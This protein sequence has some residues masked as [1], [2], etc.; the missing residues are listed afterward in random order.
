MRAQYSNQLLASFVLWIDNKVTT[1]GEAHTTVSTR[2][3][4][5]SML[6]N[7]YYTYSAPYDQ[8]IADSSI[9]GATIMTGVYVNN[10]FIGTGQ[11]GLYSI[12]YQN[13]RTYF[14]SELPAGTIISGTYS[15]KDYNVVMT[16]SPD[17]RILFETRYSPKPKTTQTLSG[18]NSDETPYPVIFVRSNSMENI[19]FEFGGTELSKDY[20][21]VIVMS[22][23]QFSN[24]AVNSIIRDT[25]NGYVPI[26]EENEFPFNYM[27]N[28]KS[29]YNYTGIAANKTAQGSAAFV[30]NIY[31][32]RFDS[33]QYAQEI[34]ELS[35]EVYTSIIDVHLSHPR[36]ITR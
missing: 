2:F 13:G 31:I 1:L 16:S 24:D 12:D 35:P 20:I 22:D 9:S 15:I 32:A 5:N 28:L 7:G 18:L 21:R 17:E 25:K 36:Q 30:E 8:I 26:L 29:G 6:Y 33:Q 19:P 4:P 27:G 10:T 14:S 23:T 3:Y 11:S 34:R